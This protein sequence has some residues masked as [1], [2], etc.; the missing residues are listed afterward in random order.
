M[1]LKHSITLILAVLCV[2]SAAGCSGQPNAGNSGPDAKAS[3]SLNPK[4]V[5]VNTFSGNEL[6]L[7]NPQRET[8]SSIAVANS[9]SLW[10]DNVVF[11]GKMS[12]RDEEIPFIFTT[13][14]PE[15]TIQRH[16]NGGDQMLRTF[17]S[18]GRIAGSRGEPIIAFSEISSDEYSLNSYLYVG[19]LDNV[20]FSTAVYENQ[21]YLNQWFLAP[22]AVDVVDG[23][24]GG[25]WY[26]TSGWGVGG[27][28]M[29]F[30]ITEGLYY[31]DT[32]AGSVK[33]YLSDNES[34]Q[35]LSPDRTLAA[36]TPSSSYADHDMTITNLVTH[37]RLT[38]PLKATS[39]QGSGLAAF[40]QDNQHAAWLE[41]G[42]SPTDDY[43]YNF[44]VRV[45]SLVDGEI[46]FEIDDNA[47]A[48]ALQIRDISSIQPLGWL[49]SG[50][51]LIQARGG[52]WKDAGI[53]QLNLADH[54]LVEFS[55]GTF[56]GFIY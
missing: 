1:K 10:S 46:E 30:P 27:P 45:G 13:F 7:V 24:A 54:S 19:N 12:G 23:Q 48:Q 39:D 15:V 18:L 26:T 6:T 20:G 22:L 43:A 55:R 52:D 14:A 8:L 41:V 29:F 47:V 17:N 49:D 51:L 33:E 16:Q 38:F 42:T 35:G 21:D 25:V 2:V 50:T 11:T 34:L 5:A 9:E 40:A 32:T 36:S 31:F 53:A 4:A 37:W 28:G 44:V 3:A 56:I